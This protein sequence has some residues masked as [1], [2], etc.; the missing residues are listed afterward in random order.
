MAYSTFTGSSENQ[1][2][3]NQNFNSVILISD[4]ICLL[5]KHAINHSSN[6]DDPITPQSIGAQPSGNYIVEGDSRLTNSRD[7]NPHSSSHNYNGTDPLNLSEYNIAFL[8]IKYNDLSNDNNETLNCKR[9]VAKAWV[10]FNGTGLVSIRSSLNISS[11]TDNG[12]GDYTINFN[13][14]F[15]NT[16]YCFVTWSRDWNADNYIV[17]NLA[18]RSSSIK[19]PMGV[20]LINNYITNSINYDSPELNIIFFGT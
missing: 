18:A 8:P 19:T 9:R 2:E 12:T 20:R 13:T 6:G 11:I 4:S 17:N 14:P 16:N 15:T 10:N 7:P 1:V 3:V 5:P